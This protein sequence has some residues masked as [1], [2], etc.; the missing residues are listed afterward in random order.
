M[1]HPKPYIILVDYGLEG[2]KIRAQYENISTALIHCY[3]ILKTEHPMDL[4]IVKEYEL[5]LTTEI[6]SV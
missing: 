5:E 6:E 3:D 2:W 1:V 4:K